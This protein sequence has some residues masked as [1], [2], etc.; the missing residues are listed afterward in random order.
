MRTWGGRLDVGST[1]FGVVIPEYTLVII[2]VGRLELIDYP[3]AAR[4]AR[5]RPA[6]DSVGYPVFYYEHQ[7]I[8]LLMT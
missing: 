8:I 5:L 1:I 3:Y 7:S 2:H 6:L 4:G